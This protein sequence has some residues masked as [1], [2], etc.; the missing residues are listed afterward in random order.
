MR[1]ILVLMIGL[2]LGSCAQSRF[3]EP[4]EKDQLAIGAGFGGPSI[5]FAGAPIPLPMT[6][7]EVG[8]GIDSNLTVHG[9]WHTTS[10]FFGNAQI[11]AGVTYKFLDQKKYIPNVS[12]SPSFNFIY[13]FDDKSARFWP[14][15]DINAYW[16]YGNR[17]NYFY[18]G[19]NNYFDLSK[20]MANDQDQMHHWIFSP[21]IG[22]IIKGK[23][24]PWQLS[25]ELKFLAPY[26][27]NTKAFVPFKS[28]LGKW[29]A[30]GFYIGFRRALNF[31]K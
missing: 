13:N 3:V 12:A 4:L 21:Q 16:N 31:K 11:D 27:D 22:H 20:T 1:A 8:Y 23:K 29:G 15:L 6:T 30:T 28:V 24:S 25:V 5:E 26:M 7:L 2:V 14:I 9:G 17:K 19:F 18:V 10:A